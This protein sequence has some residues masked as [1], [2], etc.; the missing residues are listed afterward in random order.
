MATAFNDG[1]KHEDIAKMIVLTSHNILERP[2]DLLLLRLCRSYQE[3]SLYITMKLQTAGR[4]SDGEEE[5]QNFGNLLKVCCMFAVDRSSNCLI[6]FQLYSSKA[7]RIPDL[8]KNWDFPKIHAHQHVFDDL[9]RKGAARN[10][11]TKIDE[12]LHGSARNAYLRQTNFKDVA[13]Q[14]ILF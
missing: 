3:L 11:G 1:T 10:F 8:D 2:I 6:S 13:P 5:F 4:I 12:A 14:V 7:S 9:R